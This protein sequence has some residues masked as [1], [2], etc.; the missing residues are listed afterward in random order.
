MLPGLGLVFCP[1]SSYDLQ[2]SGR[3]TGQV[4]TGQV[5]KGQVGTGQGFGSGLISTRSE[6]KRNLNP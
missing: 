3:G 6:E 2:S 5:D 1:G 4:G